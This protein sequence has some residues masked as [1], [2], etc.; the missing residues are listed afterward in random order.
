MIVNVTS[1]VMYRPLT[2]L[3]VYSASKAAVNMFTESLALELEPL[4]VRARIVLP[5]RAPQTRFGENAQ[6]PMHSAIPEAYAAFAKR[7]FDS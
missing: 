3:S 2:L 5:E 7:M 1:T 6:T 4:G